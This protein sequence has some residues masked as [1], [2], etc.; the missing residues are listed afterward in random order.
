MEQ[1][2][3][4]A[5]GGGVETDLREILG[6]LRRRR[7]VFGGCVLLITSLV[8][9]VAYQLTPLYTATSQV[10]VDPREPN[11]VDLD[12]VLSGIAADA[13]TI[14]SQMEVIRSRSIAE[15]VVEAN[16]LDED[17][18]FNGALRPPS[19][20]ATIRA[21]F[22]DRLG[23]D[24]EAESEQV[25]LESERSA[26]VDAF[27]S[28]LGVTRAGQRSFVISIAVTSEDPRKASR[29]ANSLADLYLVAQLEAKFDATERATDWLSDRLGELRERVE[30]SEKRVQ[31]YR[32][33]NR[34]V[35][36]AGITIDEQQLA[37]INGQLILARADLAEKE[38][39]FRH[40]NQLQRSGAGFESLAEVLASDVVR[41][42]RRQQASLARE[43]ADLESRYGELHPR[44][45][46]ARNQSEES[47]LEL[48]AEVG[49]IVANL[50]NEVAVAKSRTSSLERSLS[51]LERQ[52]STG[53]VARIRLRELE[54]E[55]SANR[56]LYESFLGRFKETSEQAGI[57]QADARIIS[58]A[59][60]SAKPSYPRK[61]LFTVLGFMV[62]LWIGIAAVILLER[63]DNGFRS[64]NQLEEV[65]GVPHLAS[66]PAVS[67]R[68]RTIDG[69]LL[70]PE[71]YVLARPFSSY[72]EA[73]GNLRSALLLPHADAPPRVVVLTS[74]L[75]REGKT[76]MTI[77][78]GRVAALSGVRT[79]VV[80]ADLR[81]PSVAKAL[82]LEPTAGLL[83][84]LAG[85]A[86]LD[87]VLVLDEATGMYVLPV[88]SSAANPSDLPGAA[89]MRALLEE[90]KKE[91]A[92]VL[93]DSAPVLAVSDTRVLGQDCDKL[94]FITQ[95]EKTPR[96]AAEEAVHVL[97]QVGV[98]IA[99]AVFSQLDLKQHAKYGYG[100]SYHERYADY[101]VD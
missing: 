84:V 33:E 88:V 16:R 56:V 35:D 38:A 34:L 45:I 22:R 17:P 50:E 30:S 28:A 11:V 82:G 65:L 51:Q 1:G 70:S 66:I 39:R 92:L 59:T 2:P 27:S 60:F 25:R 24:L 68:D 81:H 55:A 20:L 80:D 44:M 43:Q 57:A 54:R 62:S 67:V 52:R 75:P 99:G 71:D 10:L 76:T 46:K 13:S 91:F 3:R 98:H 7:H 79:V 31:A 19:R 100:D 26:V 90:L 87:D 63:L 94:V 77:S 53:E 12:S 8:V 97:R 48:K 85:R 15:R 96:G 32:V 18:E 42:L 21:W 41:D 95:W 72:A 93:V 9:L 61:G 14:D 40:V 49:R 23:D 78:L 74:A 69:R 37:E 58:R 89:S 86:S 73:L 64:G 101:Y 29:L 83:E 47:K 36:S 5:A 6:V 4:P